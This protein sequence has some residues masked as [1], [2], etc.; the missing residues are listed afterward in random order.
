MQLTI[1]NNSLNNIDIFI[2]S[3]LPGYIKK[4]F[5]ISVDK[6]RFKPF[7]REYK[8]NSYSLLKKALNNLIISKNGNNQY[9]IKT[10]NII[11]VNNLTLDYYLRLI[12]Y[13]TREIKGYPLISELFNYI[14]DNINKIYKEWDGGN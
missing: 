4:L 13:G 11:K 3:Y 7:D 14:K 5:E 1:S 9:I 12:N 2:Y 6:K 8:I 10:N